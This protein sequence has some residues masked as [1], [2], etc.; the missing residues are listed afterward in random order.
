M[1]RQPCF[2]PFLDADFDPKGR[3]IMGVADSLRDPDFVLV[4]WS[5]GSA[6]SITLEELDAQLKKQGL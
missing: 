3:A 4:A 1:M 6:E 5:D 2:E